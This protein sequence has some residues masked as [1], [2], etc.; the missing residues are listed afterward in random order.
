VTPRLLLYTRAGCHLCE[1]AVADLERLRR[2]HP[3]TLEQVDIDS[4]PQ[5]SLRY[6]ERIPVLVVDENEYAAPLPSSLL[7]RALADADAR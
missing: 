4:D 3:H 6:G 5:L 2:R 7:E 1:Q